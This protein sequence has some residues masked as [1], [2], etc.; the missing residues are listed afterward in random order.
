[1][2][3]LNGG[4]PGT[5]SSAFDFTCG[6]DD[7]DLCGWEC[8]TELRRLECQLISSLLQWIRRLEFSLDALLWVV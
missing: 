5:S 8:C 6:D 4:V 1:V 2:G 7:L 3:P